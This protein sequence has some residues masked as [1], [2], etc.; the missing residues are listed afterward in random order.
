MR[1]I[2]GQV[3]F[4]LKCRKYLWIPY[5]LLESTTKYA[6]YRIGLIAG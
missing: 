3:S 2:K 5:V 4:I 6:G 1:F